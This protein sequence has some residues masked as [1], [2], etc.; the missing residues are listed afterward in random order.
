MLVANTDTSISV[1][2]GQFDVDVFNECVQVRFLHD[3]AL[4]FATAQLLPVAES[5]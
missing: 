2:V 1:G 5:L 4:T 3:A